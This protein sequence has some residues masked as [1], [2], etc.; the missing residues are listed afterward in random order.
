L[1]TSVK[2]FVDKL[3]ET[4]SSLSNNLC[5]AGGTMLNCVTN[6]RLL[7]ESEFE[8]VYLAPAA[9]DDGLSIGGAMFVS[10]MLDKNRKK[11]INQHKRHKTTHSVL[12]VF[13]G[14][15]SYDDDEVQEALSNNASDI[16]WVK[17]VDDKLVDLIVDDIDQGKV[18]G[19]FQGGSELGPRALGHRSILGD[20][21][22]PDMKDKINNKVKHR[23]EF[24]PFAPVVPLEDA[25]AW[26]ELSN[27]PSPYMLFSVKCK[28]PELIPSGVHIDDTSRVQTVTKEDNGRFYQL[29]RRFGDKTKVPVII[30]TSFN[31]QGQPIVESPADAIKCF[32]K[33][34]ID[35]L[36]L[37]NYVVEKK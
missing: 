12:E 33:T 13:E 32:L 14:G 31:V 34:E 22:D 17:M 30:N 29:V 9:G 19:W 18:V 26:F 35:V 8:N 6:G 21:R 2:N 28:Q 23:E 5:L 16:S 11:E 10:H 4:A 3:H 36:V 7:N 37:E 24:R 15:K 25:D 20:A 1:E 27:H